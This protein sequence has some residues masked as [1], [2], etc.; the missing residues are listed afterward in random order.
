MKKLLLTLTAVLFLTGTAQAITATLSG[1]DITM[2]Y[3][4]PTTNEDGTPLTDLNEC[5]ITNSFDAQVIKVPAT[6][7]TGGG[8]GVQQVISIPVS[9]GQEADIIVDVV[10]CDTSD[11]CSVPATTTVRIDRLSPASPK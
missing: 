4:E 2:S 10:A 5:R 1:V 6:D 7:P 9:D 8:T 11:N 3:D